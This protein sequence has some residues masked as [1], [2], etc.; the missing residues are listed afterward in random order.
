M[1]Y[2]TRTRL[3]EHRSDRVKGMQEARMRRDSWDPTAPSV[4][5]SHS[6][7]DQELVEPAAN[8][9]AGLGVKVYVDWMDPKMPAV[10]SKET[11]II[12]KLC[13]RIYRRFLVLVTERSLASRWVPW[14]LG[15]A[16]GIK[17]PSDLAIWPIRESLVATAPNE[18]IQ[19]YPRIEQASD[20]NWYVFQ[21][22]S[23]QGALTVKDWLL[24]S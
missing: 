5:L 9:L 21:P 14:E 23:S 22:S 7:A 2:I 3:L 18:Y 12:L 17:K 6:H 19:I 11:A 1:A 24:A 8:F 20:N 10:T 4:F 15:Y 13:I 16:D